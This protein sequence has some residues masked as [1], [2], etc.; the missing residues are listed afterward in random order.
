MNEQTKQILVGWLIF[1][2]IQNY[3]QRLTYPHSGII[4]IGFVVRTND[5]TMLCC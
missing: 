1:I 4:G 5:G 3:V 2:Q